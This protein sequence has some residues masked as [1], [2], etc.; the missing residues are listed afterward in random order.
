VTAHPEILTQREDVTQPAK[1]V[2]QPKEKSE[3]TANLE[4][5]SS[6]TADLQSILALE[7]GQKLEDKD[8]KYILNVENDV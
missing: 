6:E 7:N 8:D 1:M 3:D 4:I 5:N 2:E